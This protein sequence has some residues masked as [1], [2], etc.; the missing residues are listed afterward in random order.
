MDRI[1]AWAQIADVGDG[2][3]RRARALGFEDYEDALQAAAAESC[4][5]EWIVT[6][7]KTDF[8]NSPVP[9]I[10]P[11]EFLKNLSDLPDQSAR[12]L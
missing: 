11:G 1:L 3:A 7:N 6:R 2:A 12:G 8:R 10:S 9:A 5:A 4:L